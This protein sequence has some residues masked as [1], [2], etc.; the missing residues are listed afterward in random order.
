MEEK[1]ETGEWST[2]SMKT[3]I[4]KVLS[5]EM[6]YKKA[7]SKYRV[8]QT[9]LERYVKK[10]KEDGEGTI[11]VSLGPKKP[12]F[13]TKEKDEIVAYL[14]HMEERLFGLTTLDLRRLAYQLVVRNGK[15]HNFNTD[16]QM[17]GVD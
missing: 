7:A 5:K 12:L 2:I 14:K 17:S 15:A 6:S 1:T 16:E 3:A 4:D 10:I 8:P 13:T 9:T 11:G